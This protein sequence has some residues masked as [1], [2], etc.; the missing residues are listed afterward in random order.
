MG[1]SGQMAGTES[2][3]LPRVAPAS[4]L[5]A[6]HCSVPSRVIPSSPRRVGFAATHCRDPGQGKTRLC[7]E[8]VEA[9][10]RSE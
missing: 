10:P 5:V 2:L 4:E 8:F 6:T 1:D 3:V 7:Y 9:P